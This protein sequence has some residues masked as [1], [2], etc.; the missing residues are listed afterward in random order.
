MKR[1][2]PSVRSLDKVLAALPKNTGLVEY[3]FFLPVDF[4][5]N[6]LRELHLAAL[7][8]LADP[9]NVCSGLVRKGFVIT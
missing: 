4:K 9:A 7:V 1:W 5:N 8:L 6:K 2:T 3:R